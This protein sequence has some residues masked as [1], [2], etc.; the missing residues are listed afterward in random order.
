M[1][2]SASVISQYEEDRGR[3]GSGGTEMHCVHG[4]VAIG[5]VRLMG[6]GGRVSGV[7]R[8]SDQIG[9]FVRRRKMENMKRRCDD[10]GRRLAITCEG[11]YPRL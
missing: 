10:R 9:E 8:E 6:E 3:K 2:I 7:E 4:V 11:R 5:F 1:R